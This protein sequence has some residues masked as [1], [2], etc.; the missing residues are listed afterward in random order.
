MIALLRKLF[1]FVSIICHDYIFTNPHAKSDKA[2]DR[3]HV[4]VVI[5]K[6][7]LCSEADKFIVGLSQGGARLEKLCFLDMRPMNLIKLPPVAICVEEPY[8]LN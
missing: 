4:I 1:N 5:E 7:R 6:P 2:N 3:K 8:I